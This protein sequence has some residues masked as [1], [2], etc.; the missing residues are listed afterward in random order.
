MN[1]S[2]VERSHRIRGQ[3][4]VAAESVGRDPESI[5]LLPASKKQDIETLRE[6][7]DAGFNRFGENRVQEALAKIEVLP[8]CLHW[9]FIGGLQRNKV[10]QVVGVFGLIHSVDS[11]KLAIEIEKRAAAAGVIQKVLLEINIGGESAKH[12]A[13]LEDVRDLVAELNELEHLEVHG[14]MC[15]AP[16]REDVEAVRPYFRRMRDERDR[17]EDE[18]QVGL[19][20][21][22]MGMSHDFEVAIEEGATIIRI[23]TALFG[24]RR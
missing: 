6:A 1:E 21:L 15:V 11:P 10:K 23:G 7:M 20:E 22:S 8:Q 13:R 24:E 4:K 16:F 2:L 19:P 9:D 14:F 3:I 18:L 5:L 12:G 17:I